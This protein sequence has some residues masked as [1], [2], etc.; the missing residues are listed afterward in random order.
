MQQIN[1]TNKQLMATEQRLIVLWK[2]FGGSVVGRWI[3]DRLLCY[4]VPYSGSI[5]P[6]VKK[7][8]PGFAEVWMQDKRKLRNHLHCIHAIALANLGELTSGL[9]MVAALSPSTRAIVSHIEMEYIKKARGT[10]TAAGVAKPPENITK[11]TRVLV[12]AEIENQQG[13]IVAVAHVMWHLSPKEP[14]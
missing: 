3:F 6:Q 1:A 11:P 8:S 13:E 10:L 4:N 9:A 5:S 7:L 14:R 12:H 2:R